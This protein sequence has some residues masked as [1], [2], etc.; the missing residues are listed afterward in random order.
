LETLREE[1]FNAEVAA[2]VGT[3]APNSHRASAVEAIVALEVLYDYLDTLVEQPLDDPLRD[4]HSLFRALIDAVDLD[5]APCG[6]YHRRHPR[7][8]DGGY[9]EELVA[10]VRSTLARLPA[11]D[12]IVATARRSATRCAEAQIRSHAVAAAGSAQLELWATRE[13]V[14]TGLDWPEFLAGGAA[15][16]L[17]LHAL[18]AAAADH[19]TTPEQ[20]AQI[21]T[22]YLSI[23]ALSTMLDSLV[24]YERDVSAETLGYIR[25]FEDRDL[26]ALRLGNVAQ[27]AAAQ[28]R[29]LPHAAHH[30]MTLAGVVAYYTSAP[31]ATG[32]FAAPVTAHI[33]A[34]LRPLITPTLAV[35]R[36]WRLAKRVRRKRHGCRSAVAER[37]A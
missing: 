4:G 26:L 34:Q 7:S 12:A 16:V 23:A 2:T 5:T 35:M 25:Y 14:G 11:A 20:A 27:H 36:A 19:R 10:T 3:L 8:V 15:S 31:S 22:A 13:A 6:G 24:D 37:S 32:E 9:L 17:T 30:L 28:A 1:G 29:E 21:D 18:I 33:N